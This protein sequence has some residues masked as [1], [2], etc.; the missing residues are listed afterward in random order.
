MSI[1]SILS[2]NSFNELKDYI[3]AKAPKKESFVSSTGYPSFSKDIPIKLHGSTAS[4]QETAQAGELADYAFCLEILRYVKKRK[5]INFR[6]FFHRIDSVYSSIIKSDMDAGHKE[7]LV[8]Y[9][10][11]LK[12]DCLLYVNGNNIALTQIIEHAHL[13]N[14]IENYHRVPLK[15]KATFWENLVK[16]CSESVMDDVIKLVEIFRECFLGNG[17]IKETSTIVLHPRFFT[18]TSP[19]GIADLYADGILYDFKATKKNGY[20]WH[21]VGQVYGYYILHKLC[22]KYD[23][24]AVLAEPVPI[25][26]VNGIGLYYSRYGNVE[27]CDL[28]SCNAALSSKET[29]YLAKMMDQ[30]RRESHNTFI[31]SIQ[32]VVA[33]GEW[34]KLYLSRRSNNSLILTPETVNYAVGDTVYDPLRGKSEVLEFTEKDGLWYVVLLFDSEKKLVGNINEVILLNWK[35]LENHKILQDDAH[36]F[37]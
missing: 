37:L 35:H 8:R 31:E 10:R 16:P 24:D 5:M 23:R 19:V 32:T 36:Y 1:T 21:D 22:T 7:I 26:R 18:H 29:A 4:T 15:V 9:Y 13:I 12:I 20:N 2:G 30:H 27:T 25:K 11:K 3:R 33:Q 6:N 14:K 17:V 28:K 34:R